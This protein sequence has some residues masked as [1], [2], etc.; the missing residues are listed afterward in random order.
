MRDHGC[1]RYRWLALVAIARSALAQP[2]PATRATVLFEQGR[3]LAKQGDFSGAC[4]RFADSYALDPATG[5]ELNL[6]DCHQHLGE[7]AE[8]WRW[9]DDA[10]TRFEAAHDKRAKFARDRRDAIAPRLG[11]IVVKLADPSA[12]LTIAGR[13][14]PGAAEVRERVDAGTIE[15]R[16]GAATR[17]A[18]VSAG[19]TVVVEF[20]AAPVTPSP[21]VAEP[22]TEHPA[23]EPTVHG[24]PWQRLA[25]YGAGGVAVVAGSIGL[26]LGIDARSRYNTTASSS[27]CTRTGGTI[28]CDPAGVTALDNAIHTANIGTGFAIAA[29]V[30]AA[31]GAVLYFT[32]PKDTIVVTPTAGGGAAGVVISGSF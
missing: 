14:V 15:V 25:A 13:V 28:A 12:K 23:E 7:N 26:G 18:S 29:A 32:A 31:S 4:S 2:A 3:E 19:S 11:T 16:A 5:T 21:P 1:V 22:S 27:Q 24:R 10:A 30:L 8:A 20:P 17:S 6:G 9:F